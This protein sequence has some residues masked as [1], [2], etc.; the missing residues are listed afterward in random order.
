MAAKA[1]HY[2]EAMADFYRDNPEM[3]IGVLNEAIKEGDH[4]TFMAVLGQICRAGMSVADLAKRT[5]LNE[6]TLHRTL[7]SKGNPTLK[8]LLSIFNALGLT[9]SAMRSIGGK[10]QNA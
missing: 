10:Q 2:D 7:S 6:T 8:T 1:I 4:E 9:L 5:G 3:A